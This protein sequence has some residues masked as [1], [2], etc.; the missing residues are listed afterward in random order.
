M[1]GPMDVNP[2]QSPTSGLFSGQQ[3]AYFGEQP[4]AG[5][6]PKIIE[7]LRQTQPW[8]RFLS[9]L[10]FI[11]FGLLLLGVLI[12]LLGSVASGRVETAMVF[13]VYAILGALYLGPAVFLGRYASNIARLR[14]TLRIEDLENALEAQK[15]FW[16]FIGIVTVMMLILYVCLIFVM[17]ATG[18]A[19]YS[20]R[21]PM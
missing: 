20:N 19:L 4:E 2:Y 21:W 17:I 10:A 16:R 15:S 11:G 7:M 5:I 9:V 1:S 13:V 6:T 18:F 14:M 8:V 3:P 12:G